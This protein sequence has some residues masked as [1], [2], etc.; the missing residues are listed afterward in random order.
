MDAKL[1]RAVQLTQLDMAKELKKICERHQIPYFLDCGSLLGAVRHQGFIPWDDDMDFGMMRE[2]YERFLQLAEKELPP[3]LFLQTIETDNGYGYAYAK[4][5]MRD[6][7]YL[8]R[9]TQNSIENHGIFIDI[10]PYDA[11]PDAVKDRKKL[12]RKLTALKMILKM[13]AKY[14]PWN[15]TEHK[16]WKRWILYRPAY[17]LSLL[18]SKEAL[19]N[20]YSKIACRYN[21]CNTSQC[22]PQ[23]AET[24]G[25]WEMNRSIFTD[26]TELGFEDTIFPAPIGYKELLTVAYGDYMSLPP[27]DKRTSTHGVLRIQLSQPGN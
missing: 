15:D 8:E 7:L 19:L 11:L 23:V 2:D 4:I 16:N 14:E 26:M 1:L 13:K 6:S 27:E 18:F 5:R 21:S 17:L 22:F 10:Y 9:V 3:E 24:F 12:Y 20:R 25:Q